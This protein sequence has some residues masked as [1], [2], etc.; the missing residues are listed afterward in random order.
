MTTWKTY[1]LHLSGIVQGVGFRP[2]VHQFALECALNGFVCNDV[3]GLHVEF[4]APDDVTAENIKNKLIKNAPKLARIDEI[5]LYKTSRT[6]YDGFIIRTGH[7]MTTSMHLALPPDYALCL[8]CRQELNDPDNRRYHYPFITCTSC[9][10]RYSIIRSLPYDRPHT[11]MSPYKQ[12]HQCESEYYNLQD[13]RYYS[14]TNSC[15][16]CGIHLSVIGHPF[17]TQDDLLAYLVNGLKEGKIIAV[18]GIGGFLLLVDAGNAQAIR[19]LRIKKNRPDKPLAIM[20]HNVEQ[21]DLW[22]KIDDPV[23][24]VMFSEVAPIVLLPVQDMRASSLCF[25]EIAPGLHAV[26]VMLPYTPLFELLLKLFVR[27]V[28]AT[29]GN[30]SHAPVIYKNEVAEQ[31]L[32]AIADEIVVHDRDIILPQDDSVWRFSTLY[33]QKIILRRSRSMAPAYFGYS[34]KQ[35]LTVLATGALNKSTFCILARQQVLIS[36]YLGNTDSLDAQDSYREV[37]E[38]LLTSLQVEPQLLVSDLHPQYFS[39]LLAGELTEKLKLQVKPIMVQHHKAHFAAILAEHNLLDQT[40]PILGVIWDGTG[41]GDDG[42]IWGGEYF[43]YHRH[44]MV[45]C[46]QLRYYP[47]L[48]GDKMAREPR[49]SALALLGDDSEVRKIIEPQFTKQEWSYYLKLREENAPLQTSSVG[50]LFDAVASLLRLSQKQS[51]EGHAA[52]LLEDAAQLYINRYGV[53]FDGS[54]WDQNDAPEHW[55]GKD[56][57]LNIISDI[58][59]NKSV[60]FIAAKFHYTLVC[61]IE[62]IAVKHNFSQVAFSGGVFQNACLV[63]LIIGSLRNKF[64]LYFHEKLSPNDENISFGQLVSVD[65]QFQ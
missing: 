65:Q 31:G 60:N 55:S 56:I 34:P 59:Q 63:D 19:N 29:S 22:S 38:H 6:N 50:R 15:P 24:E 4:N 37:L 53:N 45:R 54:Y 28:V 20:C 11:T 1:H 44:R 23:K 46:G 39:T 16:V 47:V 10:P 43:S 25:D 58:E 62:A 40:E 12:C 27:P 26:G 49:L 14:Q 3:D 64:K 8:S 32:K 18:K 9:G 41:L 51:Y 2:Y 61:I 35:N 33:Q 48:L 36:Q 21:V 17:S 7:N 13:R 42:Q 30:F 57:C 5:K 52:L